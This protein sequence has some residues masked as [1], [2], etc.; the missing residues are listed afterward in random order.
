LPAIT[1]N[2]QGQLTA[3]ANGTA[4][5]SVATGTG[6]TG[7]PITGTGTVSIAT[8]GVTPGNNYIG[9]VMTI[10]A[11]GQITSMN[12]P[13]NFEV[14]KVGDGPIQTLENLVEFNT[15]P[16]AMVG[17][18][19]AVAGFEY[20]AAQEGTFLVCFGVRMHTITAQPVNV[21]LYRRQA[22][23]GILT[24]L[25]H[26]AIGAA[27]LGNAT[28]PMTCMVSVGL[29]DR[30]LVKVSQAFGG[31]Y[32]VGGYV[33]GVAPSTFLQARRIY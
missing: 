30:L 2:A 12:E 6:L 21:Y 24:P 8:T 22:L 29:N 4:V 15:P 7:G 27:V 31:T 32:G 33:A 14:N 23:T 1:V 25:V 9:R 13:P 20:E 17:F 10:N 26:T 5:T 18:T 11:Q 19:E 28:A 3:A 16:V